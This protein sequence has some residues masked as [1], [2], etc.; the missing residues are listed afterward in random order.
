MAI[1][2]KF[3]KSLDQG[4]EYAALLLDLSKAFDCLRRDLVIAKLYVYGFD[5]T[6]LKLMH[7]YFTDRYQRVKINNSYTL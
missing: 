2:E 5:K 6:S 4:D 1:I 7:S 3:K